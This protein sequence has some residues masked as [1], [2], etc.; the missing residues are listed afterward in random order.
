M[1][2]RAFLKR[3]SLMTG[4]A[5]AGGLLPLASG[6]LRAQGD[7]ATEPATE[8]AG[9]DRLDPFLSGPSL[10]N[11]RIIPGALVHFLVRAADTGGAYALMEGRGR[12]GM[13]PGRHVHTREDETVHVLDGE[14]W[15]RVGDTELVAGPGDLV[16]M[17]RGIP[18]EFKIRSET[19]HVLLLINPGALGE[20]FYRFSRPAE[21]LEIPPL[22]TEPPSPEQIRT[23]QEALAGYGISPAA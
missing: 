9:A 20:Y 2:R 5:T 19:M 3:A 4:L 8:G 7:P 6:A 13:E 17:P 11:A 10:D 12:Q 21:S 14:I 15:F 18:H 23:M 16:F 1:E 22:P